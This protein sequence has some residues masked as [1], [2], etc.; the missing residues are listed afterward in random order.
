MPAYAGFADLAD[1]IAQRCAREKIR[2]SALSRKLGWA[3][4]Y[5]HFLQVGKFSPS[6]DRAD[7]I[8]NFFGDEPRV[9]RT[10]AG[11][12]SQP[13][14]PKNK[15]IQAIHDVAAKLKPAAQLEALHYL[16]YLL[17]HHNK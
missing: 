10:L 12:E 6:R 4:N 9:V 17:D 14:S 15:T 7:A 16:N 2:P 13:S 3:A 5:I 11:L 1:Y 8:A